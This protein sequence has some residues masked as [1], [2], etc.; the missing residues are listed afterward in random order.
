NSVQTDRAFSYSGQLLPDLDQRPDRCVGGGNILQTGNPW[1]SAVGGDEVLVR[2]ERP[3][4]NQNHEAG[5]GQARRGGNL[6]HL[7]SRKGRHDAAMMAEMRLHFLGA[8][9][10]VTG[11]QY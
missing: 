4:A 10:T 9:R 5:R 1:E 6:A 7:R 3:A 8:T 2:R 11:S